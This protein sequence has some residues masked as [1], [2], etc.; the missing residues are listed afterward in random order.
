MLYGVASF[1]SEMIGMLGQRSM[2]ASQMTLFA[3]RS[4]RVSGLSSALVWTA[5]SSVS[6]RRFAACYKLER[7]N[8]EQH[9]GGAWGVFRSL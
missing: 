7:E 2:R 9:G 1:S 6:C 3:A 8:M 4:A 5:Q